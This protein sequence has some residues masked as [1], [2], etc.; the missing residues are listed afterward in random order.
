MLSITTN[1]VQGS[2][3]ALPEGPSRSETH[4]VGANAQPTLPA[5]PEPPTT[6]A[7]LASFV[8]TGGLHPVVHKPPTELFGFILDKIREQMHDKTR[9]GQCGT[10]CEGTKVLVDDQRTLHVDPS[11][12][13][14]L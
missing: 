13:T 6:P 5:N 2:A 4:D 3:S 11:D 8:P 12:T 7:A 10:T 1:L 9:G 14:Q